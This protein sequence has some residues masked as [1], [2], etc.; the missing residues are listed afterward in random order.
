MTSDHPPSGA[1]PTAPVPATRGGVGGADPAGQAV[2]D[3]LGARAEPS[4]YLDPLV[5]MQKREANL[6]LV[7]HALTLVPAPRAVLK[8][9][10]FEEAFGEDQLLGDFPVSPDLLCGVDAAPSTT[11]RAGRRFAHIAGGLASADLRALP[12]RDGTFDLVL[13][14]SSLDHFETE[15]E[16]EVALGELARVLAPD[17]VLVL[18]LDNP[19]NPLYHGLRLASRMGIM[20]FPLGVTPTPARLRSSLV[21]HGLETI[22]RRWIIH[23][24]RGLSTVICLGLRGLLGLRAERPVRIL[25][26]LFALQ[27]RLPIRRWTA[28]FHAVLAR[29]PRSSDRG[30]HATA[31]DSPRPPTG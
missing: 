29:K 13:S 10:L 9:D 22:G 11:L 1:S 4:W 25:L 21:S 24:P 19:L 15:E 23:N 2:W 6:A 16:F 3:E 5:A 28:C 20:P 7:R 8:T 27:G 14:T 31:E 30:S 12:Y 26:F 17:G 18:T